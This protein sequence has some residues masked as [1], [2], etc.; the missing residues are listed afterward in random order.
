MKSFRFFALFA[1][2]A[3][4]FC[5]CQKKAT[6]LKAD[7]EKIEVP[8]AGVSGCIVLHSDGK[9]FKLDRTPEWA[10]VTLTDSTLSY[11]IAQNTSGLTKDGDIV[12]LN[13]EQTLVIS[14]VQGTPATVLKPKKSSVSF[15]YEGGTEE[16][17]VET[18][19]TLVKVEATDGFKASYADGKVTIEAAPGDGN[20]RVEGKVTLHADDLTA[21][22]A[23][24]VRSK[25]CATCG[26]SGRVRCTKCGGEG[27]ISVA[28]GNCSMT[29]FGCTAC[30]G[31]GSDMSIGSGRMRCPSCGGAGH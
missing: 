3:C 10:N 6:Y 20:K 18:D 7:V 25:V 16:V 17:E 11:S 30:G 4:I 23:A 14:I 26:G 15:S 21:E 2:V 12:V 19:A 1:L 22:I 29:S 9:D 28:Y 24:T 13:G 31:D 8:A 5:A 27:F